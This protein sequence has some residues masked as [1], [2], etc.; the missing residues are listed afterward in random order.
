[1]NNSESRAAARLRF[2][3]IAAIIIAAL[4]TI[5]S[6]VALLTSAEPGTRYLSLSAATVAM[7]LTI[8]ASVVLAFSSLFLFKGQGIAA[9]ESQGF[10]ITSALPAVGALIVIVDRIASI[11]P[12]GKPELVDVLLIITATLAALL[13]LAKLLHLSPTIKIL[14]GYAQIFFALIFISYLYLEPKVELNSP[15]KLL[16]QFALAAVALS[17]LS[18]IRIM[19][20]RSMAG[21]YVFTK[22]CLASLAFSTAAATVT[23]I[24]TGADKYPSA[25]L[26][27]SLFALCYGVYATAEF[28]KASIKIKSAQSEDVTKESET[29]PTEKDD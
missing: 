22:V 23:A 4:S 6:A 21:A 27:A 5:A 15:V 20:C 2:F 16:S 26:S 1:M 3:R 11:L 18:D 9:N 25:Y 29:T 17:T 7:Y 12:E 13:P 28:L 14:A 8:A 24:A 10:E 19:I